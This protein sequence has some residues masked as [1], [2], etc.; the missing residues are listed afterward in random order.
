MNTYQRPILFYS[1]AIAIPWAFWFMAGYISHLT[2]ANSTY[3]LISSIIGFLGLLSPALVA[4]FMT[5]KNPELR[6]DIFKRFFNFRN[7]KPVYLILTCFLMLASIL[8]AQAISLLFGY[9]ASQ[10]TIPGHFTFSSGIFPVWFILIIAPV[11]EELAWHSYGTDSLRNRFNLFITSIIF[12][13]FWALWHLPLSFIKGYYQSNLVDLGWIHSL[14]FVISLIPYVLLMNWLY[15]KTGRNILVAIVFHITA[16]F[17]NE[18]FATHPDS[19]VIQTGIL[20]ILTIF[21]VLKDKNF[22]FKR[23]FEDD[24]ERPVLQNMN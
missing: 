14:N 21:I 19:K 23:K 10:F 9:S 15:Y 2:P 3:T 13:I 20:L 16:G 1:L 12:A 24:K 4:F 6:N 18:I 8:L 17:F 11:L 7:I 5:I 22:F